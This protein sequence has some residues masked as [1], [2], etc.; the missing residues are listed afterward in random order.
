MGVRS[1]AHGSPRARLVNSARH[2]AVLFTRRLLLALFLVMVVV[3]WKVEQVHAMVVVMLISALMHAVL[4][5][6]FQ[7]FYKRVRLDKRF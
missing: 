7:L 5:Q 1:E 4:A 3:A 2:R 6:L